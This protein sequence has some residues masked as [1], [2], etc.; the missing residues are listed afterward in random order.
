MAEFV[1][2]INKAKEIC[3]YYYNTEGCKRC[4]LGGK[5]CCDFPKNPKEV[6]D[7]VLSWEKKVYPTIL[8]VVRYITQDLPLEEGQRWY[9]IPLNQLVNYRIPE[10]TAKEFNIMPINECGLTKYVDDEEMESEWR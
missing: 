6:E 8:E 3:D 5:Y 9:D 1:K 7:I 2:V 4:P 10:K